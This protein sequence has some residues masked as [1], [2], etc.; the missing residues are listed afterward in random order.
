M[1]RKY[2][3]SG[4]RITAKLSATVL[5]QSEYCSGGI[6]VKPL[7]ASYSRYAAHGGEVMMRLAWGA[8]EHAIHDIAVAAV[9][10]DQAVP[11]DPPDI[12]SAGH[13]LGG[14]LRDRRFLSLVRIREFGVRQEQAQFVV[15]EAQ[16]AEVDVGIFEFGQFGRERIVIPVGKFS[17]LVISQEIG[18]LLDF[19][20]VIQDKS[21]A[22]YPSPT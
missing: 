3:P 5:N 15:A 21:P 22:P 1:F 4:A 8:I 14:R 7:D 13:R 12:A 19:A 20:E 9:A 17:Q 10:A 11:A 18:A 2:E 16:I 6:G